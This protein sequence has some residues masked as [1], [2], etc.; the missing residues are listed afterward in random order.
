[1]STIG[2]LLK[3]AYEAIGIAIQAAQNPRPLLPEGSRH[4]VLVIDVSPSMLEN[5]W[6]PNRLQAAQK[7]AKAYTKRLVSEESNTNV[8]VVLFCR[9]AHTNCPLTP[10]R[11][12]RV[13]E[14]AIDE[15][16]CDGGTN[17]RAGLKEVY[18]ILNGVRGPCQVILLTDG[19]HNTGKEPY[20]IAKRLRKIATLETIGIGG[21]PSDVDEDLLK[22]ISSSYPDGRKRYRWIGNEKRLVKEFEQ[23]AGRLSKA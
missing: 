8:A 4:A 20:D 19:E 12:Q 13:L 7:A 18:S 5:D 9:Y 15:L 11:E 17:I 16:T 6:K 14:Q 23:L 21:S 10:V 2:Q 22:A 1:M 3:D